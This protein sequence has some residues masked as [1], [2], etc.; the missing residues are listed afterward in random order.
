MARIG[1]YEQRGCGG[2]NAVSI[3]AV[4][5]HASYFLRGVAHPPYSGRT[6]CAEV[7]RGVRVLRAGAIVQNNS[8]QQILSIG[9]HHVAIVRVKLPPTQAKGERAKSAQFEQFGHGKGLVY[10]YQHAFV[11]LKRLCVGNR[12]RDG[13][14]RHCYTAAAN[15]KGNAACYLCNAVVC[16][17][18]FGDYTGDL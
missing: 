2:V 13:G 1:I 17:A 5:Q 8:A 11:T 12:Q 6:C 9:H 7:R 4:T 14:G 3:K 10:F 15:R 18:K 16:A